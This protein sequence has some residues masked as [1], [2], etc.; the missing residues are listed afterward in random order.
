LEAIEIIKEH[1]KDVRIMCESPAP[2][3]IH[4]T[5]YRQAQWIERE[6]VF[7]IGMG[8]DFFPG[9]AIED[10]FLLDHE[11]TGHMVKSVQR[12]SKN[13][14]IMNN[15]L[16]SIKGKL[17]CSYNSFD[18][19]ENREC[20]PAT[21][22]RWLQK[23]ELAPADEIGFVLE[24]TGHFIDDGDFWLQKGIKYGAVVSENEHDKPPEAPD[25]PM[26]DPDG[27]M[28]DQ[29]LSATSLSDYLSCKHKFFL[30]HILRLKEIKDRDFDALGWL[31]PLETGIIYHTVFEKFL[32]HAMN[33][34]SVLSDAKTAS[35]YIWK[36]VDTE[37]ARCEAELPTG[38]DFH[39]ERQSEEILSNTGRF[40]EQEVEL[41][42]QRTAVQAEMSFGDEPI[43]ID[44]GD[45]KKIKA[46]GVIDRINITKSGKAEIVDYKTGSKWLFDNLTEPQESGITEANAQLAL[47]YLALR[48]IAH[49]SDD[50]EIKKLADIES[51]S[52][53][54]ITAKGDY[55]TIT[56]RPDDDADA[57]YKRAFRELISEIDNGC[58]PPE[59][60]AVNLND[61]SEVGCLY[62]GFKPVCVHAPDDREF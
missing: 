29:V 11:R 35:E 3:K 27:R 36:L 33:E 22:F 45:D 53:Q 18:T 56:I 39:T 62:C 8:S 13:I 57:C 12:I 47:Y 38:S 40:A 51:I 41:L 48:E 1:M 19:V 58:F 34:P 37:I 49:A 50:P 55:D 54:F 31:S 20:F 4:L 16:G 28:S 43:V 15:L 32:H 5:T 10:P 30:K 2:G 21:I 9:I 14:N 6:N 60:G 7:L 61:D 23:K 24:D 25:S 17:T 26:W 59:K 52:Y 42:S 44:L 46:S